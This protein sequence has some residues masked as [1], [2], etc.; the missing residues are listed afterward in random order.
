MPDLS[1]KNIGHV[2][3]VLNSEIKTRRTH[4]LTLIRRHEGG[5][6]LR[7]DWVTALRRI[8]TVLMALRCACLAE[9]YSTLV[10]S[11]NYS[12]CIA[13][14]HRM[15]KLSTAGKRSSELSRL[16]LSSFQVQVQFFSNESYR[17]Q[18]MIRRKTCGMTSKRERGGR[19][20][21]E[22]HVDIDKK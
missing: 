20:P 21:C 5:A 6:L 14:T 10:R 9:H 13:F 16:R 11:E 3:C 2:T 12:I 15:A 18:F 4:R 8:I 1:S 19:T 17:V 22:E 7:S